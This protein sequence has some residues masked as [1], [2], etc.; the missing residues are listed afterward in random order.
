MRERIE[1][2][3]RVEQCTVI[4]TDQIITKLKVT[5]TLPYVQTLRERDG[6]YVVHWGIQRCGTGNRNWPL[7]NT[8]VIIASQ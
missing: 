1:D 6:L 3:M 4:K 5:S 2:K 8:E 7:R